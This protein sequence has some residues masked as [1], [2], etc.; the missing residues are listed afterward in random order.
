MSLKW[1]LVIPA[2]V[3]LDACGGGGDD[4]TTPPP[5]QQAPA[6]PK[7]FAV[8]KAAYASGET[9]S[10]SGLP[11]AASKVE[12][13]FA[14]GDRYE[15]PVLPDGTLVLPVLPSAYAGNDAHLTAVVAGDSYESSTFKTQAIAIT[16]SSPGVATSLY[17]DASIANLTTAIDEQVTLSGDAANVEAAQLA[18]LRATLQGL[19]SAI[20]SAQAG[21]PVSIAA[22]GAAVIPIDTAQ[23][24]QFDQYVAAMLAQ[25]AKAPIAPSAVKLSVTADG[26]KSMLAIPTLNCAG[27]V[28]QSDRAWCANMQTQIANDLII[29]YAGMV[30]SV[31]GALAGSLAALAAIGVAGVA[32]PASVIGAVALAT[33]VAA[34]GIAGG[35]QGASAYGTGTSQGTN[36]RDN[37]ENLVDAARDLALAQLSRLLPNGGSELMKQLNEALTALVADQLLKNV[38]QTVQN[39][40]SA[41]PSCTAQASSGGQ[42]NFAKRYDFGAAR[43][44][45]LTYQ[46][47]TVPDQFSV[48]DAAGSLG[49][50]GGLVSGGGVVSVTSTSRYVT[51][52]V[53]A[54]NAGTAWDYVIACSS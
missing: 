5:S 25:S 8:E 40:T 43:G 2:V 1:A 17:L 37:I 41:V 53:N 6:A 31:G 28:D 24:Q 30:G 27:L 18:T 34:N 33:V 42:G 26:K 11:S 22:A 54:P 50:T 29:N 44:L 46:A 19:K 49:G 20:Q 16:T 13:V 51:V 14:S 35:V 7:T 10:L 23:L 9:I 15:L 48:F 52:K 12:L 3:L 21:V 45:T 47:Y 32:F 4:A 38:D 36:V 39:N